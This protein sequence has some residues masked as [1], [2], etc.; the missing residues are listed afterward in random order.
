[1]QAAPRDWQSRLAAC[2]EAEAA[3]AA[4]ITALDAPSFPFRTESIESGAFL[5]KNSFV[6]P[7]ASRFPSSVLPRCSTTVGTASVASLPQRVDQGSCTGPLAKG[8][9]FAAGTVRCR[10]A[11][12]ACVTR[13]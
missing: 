5:S 1:M 6:A 9:L 13:L 3:A 12:C 7:T 4:A 2:A 11:P 10:S 8:V